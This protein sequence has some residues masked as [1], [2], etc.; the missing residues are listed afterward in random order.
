[1]KKLSDEE[2]I[3]RKKERARNW[4]LKNKEEINKKCMDYHW[5]HREQLLK[6]RKEYQLKNREKLNE[7]RR[8]RYNTI[9]KK[10]PEIMKKK[11]E[12]ARKWDIE[13]RRKVI[14]HYSNGKMCCEGINGKECE[15]QCGQ[16]GNNSAKSRLLT[17][18]HVNGGGN[19]HR[20]EL[21][22][23][24]C[25]FV[26]KNDFPEGYRILCMN[27][28]MEEARQKGFYGTRRFK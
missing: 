14:E 15:S 10:N 27:C 4:Y 1:M 6:K 12:N 3:K 17:I 23:H 13:R 19:K 18:D 22:R 26:I 2:K 11:L 9:D 20:K 21:A 8:K 16:N 25:D 7:Q 24:L 5:L 28:N